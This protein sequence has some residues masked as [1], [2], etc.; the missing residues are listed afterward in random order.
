M[1]NNIELSLLRVIHNLFILLNRFYRYFLSVK[2]RSVTNIVIAILA[3]FNIYIT[4]ELTDPVLR[5]VMILLHVVLLSCLYMISFKLDQDNNEKGAH[6]LAITI[7]TT[8][9]LPSILIY[10]YSFISELI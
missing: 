4:L 7:F 10:S 2:D 1:K 9:F 8:L 5:L 3:A 6:D